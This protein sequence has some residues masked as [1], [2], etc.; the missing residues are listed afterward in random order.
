MVSADYQDTPSCMFFQSVP[1][2]DFGYVYGKLQLSFYRISDFDLFP[3]GFVEFSPI[4]FDGGGNRIGSQTRRRPSRSRSLL[5]DK[6]R[7]FLLEDR[8]IVMDVEQ[9]G[10]SHIFDGITEFVSVT[11][12]AVSADPAKKNACLDVSFKH[13]KS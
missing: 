1:H 6:Y 13:F 8:L 7:R 9:E 10:Q 2:P 3:S 12:K 4:I 11:V 5:R